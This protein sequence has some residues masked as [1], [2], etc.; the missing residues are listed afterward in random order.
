[1]TE[2]VVVILGPTGRNF[3]AGMSSGIVYVLDE[4]GDFPGKL[5]PELVAIKRVRQYGRGRQPARAVARRRQALIGTH[6]PLEAP[7]SKMADQHLTRTSISI[8]IDG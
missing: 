4:V 6:R 7:S 3:G 1:M 5:N 8:R 2:G